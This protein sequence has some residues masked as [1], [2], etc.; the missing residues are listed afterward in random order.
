MTNKT[1]HFSLVLFL[2]SLLGFSQEM[3]TTCE[4]DDFTYKKIGV[5]DRKEDNL[6]LTGV[7]NSNKTLNQQQFNKNSN[8][9]IGETLGQLSVSSTGGAIYN[10]PIAVPTGINGVVPDISLT[11]NSQRGNGEAG[12][13]WNVSGVSFI[14]RIPSSKFY[15]GVIDEVDFDNLD[16]FALD[17]KRLILKSGTYAGDGAVYETE[18]Y[19][20]LKIT[21]YGVS[22]FGAE[23]GPAYFVVN[24]PDGSIGHYGANNNSITPTRYAITYWQNPQGL[25]IKYEYNNAYELNNKGSISIKKIMYGGQFGGESINEIEFTTE[26]TGRLEEGYIKDRVFASSRRLKKIEVKSNNVTYRTYEITYNTTSLN[27]SRVESIT[28]YSGDGTLNH[29]PVYFNY[30]NT[31]QT[32]TA[33]DITTDLG[34]TNIE[35]RNSKATSLDLTGNGKMD[36]FITPL[37]NKNKFWLFKDLEPGGN[38]TPYEINTGLFETIFPVNWINSNNKYIGG[39]GIAVVQEADVDDVKFKVYGNGITQPI[40]YQYTKTWN[41]PTYNYTNY[42]GNVTKKAIPKIYVSGDFNGDGLTDVLAIGKAYTN[43]YCSEYPCRQSV[44]VED[45]SKS[46]TKLTNESNLEF[47]SRKKAIESGKA[48]NEHGRIP[49]PNDPGDPYDPNDP[50]GGGGTCYS[51]GTY[52]VNYNGVHFIDLKQDVS[53]GITGA[54]FTEQVVKDT[55][56]IYTGD[57]NGDGKTDIMHVTDGKLFVSSLNETGHLTLLWEITNDASIQ[58]GQNFLMGDFN[59]DGKTDFMDPIGNGS[60]K[61][62]TYMSTGVSFHKQSEFIDFPFTYKELDTQTDFQNETTI[63]NGYNLIAAD[64][65][66]DGR[67]DIVEY[68]TKTYTAH[69]NGSQTIKVYKNMGMQPSVNVRSAKFQLGGSATRTGNLRLYPIP[70]FLTSNQPTKSLSFASI[71]NKW[72][73]SFTFNMDHRRDVLL[74][75]VI[76]NAVTYNIDYNNLDPFQYN[77]TGTNLNSVYQANYQANYPNVNVQVDPDTYV[78][79]LLKRVCNNTETLQQEYFYKGA[80]FNLEGLGFLGFQGMSQSNWHTGVDDVIYSTSIYNTELRGAKEVEYITPHNFSF[81]V[82]TSNYTVKTDYNNAF[83][84]SASKVFKLWVTSSLTQNA[85]EGININT[86]Y[87]YDNYNNPTKIT[88]NYLGAGTMTSDIIYEN[89]LGTNYYVGRPI[90][91]IETKT[92]GS[93]TFST[94]RQYAYTNY[95]LTEKKTKGNNT[96]FDSETF[97]YDSYGNVTKKITSPHNTPSREIN[98]EYD[99]SKRFLTKLVNVEGLAIQYEYN[100]N[101][102]TLTKEINP[103]GQETTYEYDSWYRP[104]KL[105]DYLGNELTNSFVESNYSYTVTDISDDGSSMIKIFDP[106]GRLTTIK[107]KNILGEWV[108]VSYEYDKFDRVSKESEPYIGNAATHWNETT[109]DFYGRPITQTL[110]TGRVIDINYNQLET[111]VNDGTKVV[112]TTKDAMGN[113]V[114]V[115]DPGGTI[116]YNYYGN[117]NLKTANY[118]GTIVSVEQDGWGRKTKL[119]DPSAGTYEY[120]YNG[121]GELTKETTPKGE[122]NYTYTNEGKVLEKHITGDNTNMHIQY[123]YHPT[124]KF[125]NTITLTNADGNNSTYNYAYDNHY[126]ITSINENNTYAQFNKTLTYDALGRIDTEE[127]YA[128]LLLNNATSTKKIKNVYQNGELKAINDFVTNETIWSL[129]GVNAWGQL[130]TATMGNGIKEENTYDAYGYLAE[131]KINKNANTSPEEIMKLNFN[132]DTQRGV[133]N[134]RTNSLFSWSETFNYDNLDR[135]VAFND[136]NGANNHTYD[137][138]GRITSNNTVGDYNYV[139]NAYKLDKLDLNNQGDLYYQQNNLQQVTYNAF[140]KPVEINE[141]GKEK[142]SY[143]YNAFMGRSHSFYGGTE[144]NAL[145]RRHRKHYAYDGSMEISYDSSTLKT[146]FVTY[147]GG[148]A[149]SA[150]VIWRSEQISETASDYYYL[151]RDYLGSILMISDADGNVKEKRHFDAWGNIVKVADGDGNTLNQ[152][153]FIDRGYTGHEHLQGVNLIHMNGRLYDAKLRRFLAPDNFIQNLG[154]TQNFNRYGYVLNNP[155]LYTDPSGELFLESLAVAFIVKALFVASAAVGTYALITNLTDQSSGSGAKPANPI[156]ATSRNNAQEI[157]SG[158]SPYSLDYKLD[159]PIG[160]YQATSNESSNISDITSFVPIINHL[161]NGNSLNGEG[162]GIT[163]ADIADTVT[164]F[165][166]FVGSVKDIYQGIRDGNGWQVALGVGGLVA[167]VFTLGSASL[168]KGV[169]K[170]GVKQGVKSYAKGVGRKLLNPVSAKYTGIIAGGN[171][172]AKASSRIVN[173]SAKQLQKKFKHAA[174]FGVNGNYN[175][176]NAGKFNSALNQHINSS[177]VKAVNGTYRGNSVTHYLDANSGLNVIVNPNGSFHSGWRL[178]SEQLMNVL[179]HGGLN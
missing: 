49:D 87:L 38:N 53:I 50:D 149:Y 76:N 39:E 81:S 154:D 10:L 45:N 17:G 111:T 158:L 128:K 82:P 21:S 166:P 34:L 172:P 6:V 33:S 75:S 89:N 146:T 175:K 119:I 127:Y 101:N 63:F 79:T 132:F 77:A 123:A 134:S 36:F 51:C 110:Y 24:Y 94:E 118:N 61:F 147:I 174:D 164:D 74:E 126:R 168:V 173:T 100:A 151:H 116:N 144:T 55:D 31:P 28:E 145:Q 42:P 152:L 104:V 124:S 122:T 97:Q 141:V 129:E 12:Y 135:L 4:A 160:V 88:D 69:S 161:A 92:I 15:D 43:K 41:A 44:G 117:G 91:E 64:V 67:T 103:F 143:Q 57:F 56:K 85:L 139:G 120:S 159:K 62:N 52:T 176:V 20:N 125:L 73:T 7:S 70:I 13:G 47:E 30:T 27:Y 48:T 59:G 14:S 148:D 8:E 162:S 84:L 170:T 106:L 155:L 83:S 136:N 177:G 1:L 102:G 137:D 3:K 71:S 22:P 46:I 121:F 18:S 171:V 96:P 140:K 165:I 16:R 109:Y 95:L 80:V 68:N 167:D 163:A 133:L 86:S 153:Q 107:D 130:T 23:Y 112:T 19:S 9:G 105:I 157:T 131:S 72:V 26:N 2:A 32:I 65:N 25:R 99:A 113:T 108:N 5:L 138:R 114:S 98:F 178:G 90:S 179:K 54:G 40:N 66:G 93:E 35:Q 169:I 156:S 11:Y 142:I 115:T 37:N 60:N 78:V 150:P 58:P 29:S